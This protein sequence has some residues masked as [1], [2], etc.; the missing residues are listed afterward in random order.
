MADEEVTP[1]V[2][3]Y[4]TN[5]GWTKPEIGASADAWGGMLNTDLD[6]IDSTVKSVSTVANAA[7]TSSQV[8]AKIAAAAYVL[9]TASTTILGGVKVDGTTITVAGGVISGTPSSGPPVTI[10]A[11][12]PASPQAGALWW[13]SVG[14]QLYTFYN[15]GNSSQWVVAVNAAA[16]LLPASTTVLGAVKVDGTSIQAATDG[17]ISTVLIPMG[18]NRLINGDMRIDQRNGGASGTANGY[19]VDRWACGL[20]PVGKLTWGQNLT[21]IAGPSGF[22]YYFGAQSSSAYTP[23]ASDLFELV[24][25]LEGD[26]VSDFAWGTA[27][28]QP[29][30]LSFWTRCTLTG[31]FSGAIS[32]YA[33]NRAY[34]F[35]FSIPTAN[36][37]TKIVVTVPGDT[38]GTWV[39]SGNGGAVSIIFDLGSGATYRG[40]AGAWTA[41]GYVGVTG[42]VRV[43]S[44]N[45]AQF[46]VTGVKLEIGST[47][48]PFNRQSLAKSLADCQRYYQGNSVQWGGYSVSGNIFYTPISLQTIMR[49]T[50]TVVLSSQSYG[51]ASGAATGIVSNTVLSFSAT[52]TATGTS[53]AQLNFTASAEL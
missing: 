2:E 20:S 1:L 25:Y 36:T 18:D 11:T 50:P 53:W 46:Y 4:T 16:S 49:A 8:D 27:S 7:Q 6:G 39:M 23:A 24:Q 51:A 9:P 37:W 17:T 19:T 44:T 5:Y 13:D 33:F 48:T 47:A 38:A 3:T 43:I 15:D 34:P 41:T 31:T 12:A 40:T 26:A 29:V 52:S 42:S 32:N 28:A 45:G 30:T 10:S 14:G 21:A 22:P 35:T